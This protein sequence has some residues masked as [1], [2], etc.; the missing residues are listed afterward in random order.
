VPGHPGRR[1]GARLDHPSGLGHL[2]QVGPQRRH[3]DVAAGPP[4][5]L[6]QRAQQGRGDLDHRRQPP[7]GPGLPFVHAGGDDQVGVGQPAPGEVQLLQADGGQVV[8]AA[9]VEDALGPPGVE[10][11]EA[12]GDGQGVEAGHGAVGDDARPGEHHRRLRLLQGDDHVVGRLDPAIDRR[13]APRD[14]DTVTLVDA[15]RPAAQPDVGLGEQRGQVERHLH[16]GHAVQ[17]RAVD[18]VEAEGAEAGRWRHHWPLT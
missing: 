1:Q 7:V 15:D 17:G 18:G 10:H 6:G 3:G 9:P 16:D 8:A 4:P 11:P 2:G 14:D 12:P 13:G 5:A